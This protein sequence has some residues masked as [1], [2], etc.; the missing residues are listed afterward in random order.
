MAQLYESEDL[1]SGQEILSVLNSAYL[2]LYLLVHQ[3]ESGF[4]ATQR[5][6]R[7]AKSP[8]RDMHIFKPLFRFAQLVYLPPSAGIGARLWFFV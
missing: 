7:S 6:F 2:I 1:L 5:I 4:P 8:E 3:F